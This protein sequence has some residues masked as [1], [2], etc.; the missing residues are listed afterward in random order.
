MQLSNFQPPVSRT[1]GMLQSLVQRSKRA[2]SFVEI[3]CFH[4]HPTGD[5][6]EAGIKLILRLLF[7][8]GNMCAEERIH[9]TRQHFGCHAE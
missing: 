2:G 6:G 4:G 9:P 3:L 5:L 7:S 1:D 8:V